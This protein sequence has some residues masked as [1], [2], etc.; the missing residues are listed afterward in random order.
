MLVVVTDV[1]VAGVEPSADG[2]VAAAVVAA[3]GQLIARV[4]MPLPLY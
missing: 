3:A 2:V 1:V 4:T